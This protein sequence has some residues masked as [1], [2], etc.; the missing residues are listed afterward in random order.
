MRAATYRFLINRRLQG[1]KLL[2]SVKQ[3]GATSAA[4]CAS[5]AK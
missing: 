3:K 1:T 5:F 4:A 2:G